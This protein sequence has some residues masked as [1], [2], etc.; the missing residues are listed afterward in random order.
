MDKDKTLSV[1]KQGMATEIWGYRFY[2]QAAERT[3]DEKGKQV[4]G[5]LVTE[6]KKHLSLLLG[7][8]ATVSKGGSWLSPKEA[9]AIADYSKANEI[10]PEASEAENLIPPEATDEE[11]LQMALDFERRGYNQY[12]SEAEKAISPEVKAM[13][14]FLAAQEDL[15]FEYLDKTLEYLKTEGTWY[16]DEKELPFFEG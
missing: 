4:F 3:A 5:T 2:E 1:L 9:M 13:W 10:F 7:E 11:A 8:Y 12:A 16:F 15:H 6:E 14:E